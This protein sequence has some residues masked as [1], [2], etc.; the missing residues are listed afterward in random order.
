MPIKDT[1]AY[2]ARWDS[3]GLDCS[4]CQYFSGPDTWPDKKEVSKCIKHNIS[5]IIELG[6]NRHKEWEWLCSE[7]T[8]N[9]GF[10]DAV[11]H[12]SEIKHTLQH[13]ILYRLYGE[14]GYLL[15]F[16]INEL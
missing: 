1:F 6:K 3:V 11:N 13:G 16:N 12:F 5:L 4:T 2:N 9:G 14:N 8:D 15:E 7:Y 10:P